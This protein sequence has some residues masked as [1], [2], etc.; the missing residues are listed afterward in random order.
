MS[1][2]L[3]TLSYGAAQPS[4]MAQAFRNR[5]NTPEELRELREYHRGQLA[6]WQELHEPY[7]QRWVYT[8]DNRPTQGHRAGMIAHHQRCLEHACK[9]DGW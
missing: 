2:M 6:Y 7:Q 3:P 8:H 9:S 4:I 5:P 1:R